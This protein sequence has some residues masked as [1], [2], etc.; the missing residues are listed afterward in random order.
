MPQKAGKPP[1]A[2]GCNPGEGTWAWTS[3]RSTPVGSTTRQSRLL[4]TE[5]TAA[6]LSRL[7]GAVLTS[8]ISGLSPCHT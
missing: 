5:L 4:T 7:P 3:S 6:L 2:G 8:V 1:G